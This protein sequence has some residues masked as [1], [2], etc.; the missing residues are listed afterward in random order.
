M[1]NKNHVIVCDRVLTK[2]EKELIEKIRAKGAEL[3]ELLTQAELHI[4]EQHLQAR[5]AKNIDEMERLQ[6]ASPYQWHAA[7]IR[8]FR[9]G[10]MFAI[11]AIVQP[12]EF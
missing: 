1:T 8:C 7:A 11:R 5:V 2:D 12:P 4:D 9:E 10:V 3:K 6:D